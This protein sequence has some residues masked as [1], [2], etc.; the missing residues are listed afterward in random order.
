MYADI[1]VT[2][3]NAKSFNINFLQENCSEI[4]FIP[5]IHCYD[6]KTS[7]SDKV[8]NLK[9]ALLNDNEIIVAMRGGSGAT[10]LMNKLTDLKVTSKPKIFIGYSDLT[11]FLNYLNKFPNITL[12]HGPMIGE[13][14][15]EKR[16]D[17]FKAAI[18][19]E[20]VTFEKAAKWYNQKPLSG[21]VIGG[22]LLLITDMLG[23]FYEPQFKD[24]ILL[25]EEINEDIDKLDRMFAQLRDSGKLK[26]LSG[27]ILGGFTK[28]ADDISLYK[29]F[30]RY[31]HD[32]DIGILYD[33]N[34]G[35][36]N[37]SDY[38]H[39]HTNLT[40]DETGIFYK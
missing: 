21:K 24:K 36:V 32:L 28:C 4:T 12:I 37:D 15:S 39:L 38:I 26:Q 9:A 3:N 17:K 40:I 10:R 19:R 13:L 14:T 18:A 1:I 6:L 20:N 2:S 23:T 16:I 11:V 8:D 35:H 33:V 30:D 25:I 27:I 5:S 7:D 31:L 29:L 22:N 34:L